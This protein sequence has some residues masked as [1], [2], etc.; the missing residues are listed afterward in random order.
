[1]TCGIDK[2]ELEREKYN[3]LAKDT[4]RD[5]WINSVVQKLSEKSY[6]EEKSGQETM[7]PTSKKNLGW[8]WNRKEIPKVKLTLTFGPPLRSWPHSSSPPP[9]Q[10]QLSLFYD[11]SALPRPKY[12]WRNC[13]I[14]E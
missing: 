7:D 14:C 8:R 5:P 11:L 6:P 12:K 4:Y 3:K 13:K 10:Q 1:M 9:Q 2:R